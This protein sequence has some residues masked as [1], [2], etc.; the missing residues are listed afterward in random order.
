MAFRQVAPLVAIVGETGTGKTALALALAQK[1]GGEIIAADSRTV[2]KTMD[3]GTAKPTAAERSLVRHHGLDMMMPDQAF[4]AYDFQQFANSAI[5]RIDA[6]GH[7]PF[8]VG[9]TGLY[10]DAV[11]YGFQFR[12]KP[13]TA[14]RQSLQQ[15]SVE[16]LR[17]NVLAA[18]MQLPSNESNRRHLIRLLESGPPP[19]QAYR[20]RANTLVLGITMSREDLE[21][22]ITRRVDAMVAD[23]LLDEVGK[24]LENYGEVEALKAPG[25]RA[26]GLYLSGAITFEEAKRRF[27]RSDMLLAKRQRTWFRRNPSIHW[28]AGE[29]IFMQAS[30]LIDELVHKWHDEQGHRLLQ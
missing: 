5:A 17:A 27:I 15:L 7:V 30:V 25:Y 10:V 19:R 2:Y 18:G 24:L 12:P 6:R 14:Q 4:S 9:G 20:L 16:T 26:F 23:G 1:Y 3:I 8:L 22:R 21:A 28:L 29:D 13:S 11:L